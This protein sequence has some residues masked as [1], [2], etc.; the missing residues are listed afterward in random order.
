[1]NKEA[2]ERTETEVISFE[3]RDIITTTSEYETPIKS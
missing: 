1:M 3:E 2:Y